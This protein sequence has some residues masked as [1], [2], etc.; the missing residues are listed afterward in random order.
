MKSR[1]FITR[2]GKR[3]PRR[4]TPW[5]KDRLGLFAAKLKAEVNKV[6]VTLDCDIEAVRLAINENADLIISHHPL[7]FPNKRI[8]LSH[9]EI[10]EVYDLLVEHKIPLLCIHTNFDIAC[11]GMNDNFARLLDINNVHLYQEDDFLFIG[12]LDAEKDI[13]EFI[14]L[15]KEKIELNYVLYQAGKNKTQ[16]IKK[17]GF[18]L[19]GGADLYQKA[20]DAN[21]DLFIS[22]DSRHHERRSMYQQGLNYLEL[23]HEVEQNIF[24]PVINSV[25]KEIDPTI[26]IFNSATQKVLDYK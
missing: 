7:L 19:G 8:A 13:N 3:Y 6:I 26:V 15:V 22:G 17:V 21:V 25:I 2:I 11:N 23:G 10:K 24:I 16:T 20:I 5:K 14:S 12:S 18:T 9:V 4:L 1:Q